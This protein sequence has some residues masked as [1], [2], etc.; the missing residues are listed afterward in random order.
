MQYFDVFNLKTSEFILRATLPT[1]SMIYKWHRE[2]ERRIER[3]CIETTDIFGNGK[4]EDVRVIPVMD[5][6]KPS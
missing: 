2:A 5:G 3:S 6:W 1:I 4:H